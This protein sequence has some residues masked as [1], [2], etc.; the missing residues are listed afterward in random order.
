MSRCP[1]LAQSGHSSALLLRYPGVTPWFR[2]VQRR[3]PSRSSPPYLD[4]IIAFDLRT[5]AEASEGPKPQLRS[6][7]AGYGSFIDKRSNY[8]MQLG[9]R[10]QYDRCPKL[11][12]PDAT[13]LIARAWLACEPLVDLGRL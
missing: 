1:L 6:L 2:G 4:A 13:D 9:A 7:E 3:W 12:H 11:R 5:A 10:F 8:E